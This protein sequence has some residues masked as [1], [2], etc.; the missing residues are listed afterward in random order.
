MLRR[1]K[2]CLKTDS[3]RSRRRQRRPTHHADA[4]AFSLDQHHSGWPD[5]VGRIIAAPGA[6]IGRTCSV[7]LHVHVAGEE[8]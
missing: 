6:A 7:A 5:A 1:I 8:Y 3:S 2:I 4:R